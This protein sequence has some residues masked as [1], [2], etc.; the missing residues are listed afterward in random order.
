M[1]KQIVEFQRAKTAPSPAPID[2][3]RQ[4]LVKAKPLKLVDK[5]DKSIQEHEGYEHQLMYCLPWV[6][7]SPARQTAEPW[8]QDSLTR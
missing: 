3:T 4:P 2:P 8:P 5:I 1:L 6:R 7:M